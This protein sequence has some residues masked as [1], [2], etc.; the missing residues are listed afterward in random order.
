MQK[1]LG[2]L[3]L[4]MALSLPFVGRALADTRKCIFCHSDINLTDIKYRDG[5]AYPV[6]GRCLASLPR[7]S[8]CNHPTD[9][10]PYRDGRTICA[11]CHATGVFTQAQGAPIETEVQGFLKGLLG[12]SAPPPLQIVDKDEL[13]TRFTSSGRSME[14][15]GFYRPYNP[16]MVYI[17]SGKTALEDG[18]VLAHELTH[19]WQ[20]RNCPQ[21]DRALVEGFA[22]WVEYQYFMSHNASERA[23]AMKR[24]SDPDYGA[25]LVDLLDREKRMG[26]PAFLAW[27]RK[28]RD[29]KSSI[30]I[31]QTACS[32]SGPASLR[33]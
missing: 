12:Y 24:N 33:G 14:V 17:M 22:S 6:C 19:A 29:L 26:R 31:R 7:C 9:Q 8:E 2:F 30:S 11:V 23:E 27:V 28:A 13:Q 21:Q 4:L 10:K 3:L 20:T 16:E 18:G 1:L 5:V 15:A 25:S 32:S